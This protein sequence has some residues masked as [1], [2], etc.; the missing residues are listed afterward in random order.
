MK[1]LKNNLTNVLNVLLATKEK[2]Y[3]DC[4]SKHNSDHKKKVILLIISTGEGWHYLEVRK[5]PTLSTEVTSKHDGDFHFLNC[6]H[7]FAAENK[8]DF[9]VKKVC[10][11]KDF[12]SLLMTSK[13]IK[14]FN[15]N[16]YQMSDKASFIIYIDLSL[17]N[18]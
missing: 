14:I 18:L 8:C 4:L 11:N 15:F 1:N 6:F 2:I 12:Y 16:Q 17:T 10:E 9:Y 7:S 13:D 5:L 3:L